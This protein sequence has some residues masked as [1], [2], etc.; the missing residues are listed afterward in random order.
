MTRNLISAS[1]HAP[2]RE[3]GEL[4]LKRPVGHV[5]LVEGGRL[6][7]LASRADYLAYLEERRRQDAGFLQRLREKA[8]PARDA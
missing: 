6:V 5:P 4:F 2:L 3:I 7:G 8:A 1:P